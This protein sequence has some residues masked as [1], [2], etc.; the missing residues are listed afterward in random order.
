MQDNFATY[1]KEHSI[2]RTVEMINSRYGD[3]SPRKKTVTR[4]AIYTILTN[5]AYIGV[6][7]INKHN[8]AP[9]E[10][11]PAVWEPIIDEERFNRVQEALQK[12][13]NRY[14][15]HLDDGR[16]V[17]LYSGLLRCGTCGQKLQGKSAWSSSTHKRYHY[18]SH[19]RDC[20]KKGMTRIDADLVHRLV[21]GWLRDISE[22]GEQ[23][24]KLLQ[25]GVK[26]VGQR[27]EELCRELTH[28]DEES[29]SLL[30]QIDA[31]ID[32]LTRT[33]TLSVR[34]SIETSITRLER[35][36]A[37]EPEKRLYVETEIKHLESLLSTSENLYG[38][39]QQ[40]IRETLETVDDDR[41]PEE[42]RKALKGLLAS[43]VLTENGI[44]IALSGS[45]NR[46]TL[47]STLFVVAPPV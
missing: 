28:I 23:F 42:A 7:E 45:V 17:Y 32:E 16:Y 25:E 26:R 47:G 14:Y 3:K 12:N 27:I 30:S 10:E 37:E 13:R 8:G 11:V 18:Y 22:N 6:R 19:A 31:R 24:E 2:K 33:E 21:L 43:L 39:Y 9:S 15:A 38:D 36:R 35:Q 40:A 20:A 46:K 34:Q 4:S 1:L 41:H 44:K 29:T 5:K